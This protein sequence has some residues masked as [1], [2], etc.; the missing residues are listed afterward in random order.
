MVCAFFSAQAVSRIVEAH[1]PVPSGV[2]TIARAVIPHQPVNLSSNIR[3]IETILSRNIFCST[4]EREHEVSTNGEGQS[5]GKD[6][7]T[8]NEPVKSSLN[9]K[10][11]A[12]L[13]SEQDHAWSFA[14]IFDGV[15]NKSGLYAIGSQ[16]PGGAVVTD[17]LDRKVFLANGRRNEFIELEGQTV[18]KPDGAE[19]KPL[20]AGPAGAMPG[21]DE[22]SK[23]IRKTG[24]NQFEIERTTLNR[25]LADTNLLA[26]SARIVPSPKNDGFR[27]YAIRPGS[28]YALLGMENGDTVHAVN[29]HPITTPDRALEVYTKL[30][31]AGRLSISY[32]RQNKTATH[33]YT[34]R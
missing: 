3:D 30:R 33:E 2:S 28:V 4:C 5:D 27:L 6:E 22:I 25:V 13:V 31:S 19:P 32:S 12:T 23:G 24:E 29:G 16:V 34:I 7:P 17:I 1:I 20:A 9:L 8:S 10:L 21:M 26:R 15:E 11:I 14:A 18:D